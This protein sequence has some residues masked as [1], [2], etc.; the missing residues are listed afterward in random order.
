MI[1]RQSWQIKNSKV[2]KETKVSSSKAHRAAKK[3]R[4]QPLC[5]VCL[6]GPK[7][8]SWEEKALNEG[9]ALFLYLAMELACLFLLTKGVGGVQRPIKSKSINFDRNWLS[10]DHHVLFELK[11]HHF[12]LL[13]VHSCHLFDFW[14][15]VQVSHA[16]FCY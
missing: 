10:R 11:P 3:E 1:S 7:K 9:M 2:K 14:I 5:I 4:A 12:W 16:S 15:F 6:L 13:D 8:G